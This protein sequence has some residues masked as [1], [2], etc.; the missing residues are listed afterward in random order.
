[1]AF[2]LEK[3]HFSHYKNSGWN[4]LNKVKAGG[5][6]GNYNKWSKEKVFETALKYNKATEFKYSKDG[7]GYCYAVRHKFTNELKYKHI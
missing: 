3:E 5:L 7:A 4:I 1:M 6:G 2:N